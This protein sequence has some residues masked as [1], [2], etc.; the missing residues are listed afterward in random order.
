MPSSISNPKDTFSNSGMYYISLH[1]KQKET[2]IILHKEQKKRRKTP[3]KKLANFA[4]FTCDFFH[5]F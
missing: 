4:Q 2:F 5:S 1:L 3:R